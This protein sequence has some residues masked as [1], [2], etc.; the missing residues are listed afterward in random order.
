MRL[1]CLQQ[2]RVL[3]LLE[4][5]SLRSLAEEVKAELLVS[6]QHESSRLVRWHGASPALSS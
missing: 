4:E 3:E 1:W 2:A 5:E 6:G